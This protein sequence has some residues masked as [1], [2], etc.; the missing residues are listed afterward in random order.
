VSAVVYRTA[1]AIATAGALLVAFP[2]LGWSQ[3]W[4]P[5]KGEG[6]VSVLYQD[7]FV[8]NHL[9][10]TGVKQDRGR[11]DSNNLLVDFTYGITDRL[12]ILLAAP[13]IRTRYTGAARHPGELDDG[14]P[15]SGFQDLRFGV[16]YNVFD[17]PVTITP[18]VG[19]SVPSHSYEY[20]AHAAFGPRVRE[21][22]VGTY[23]G[24]VVALGSRPAFV[25]ARLAYGF[26]EEIAGIDRSRTSL[27]F[28]AG[29]FLSRSV[30]VF[31]TSAGQKTHGGIDLPDA[32]WRAMPPELQEHHDRIARI[33]V[34]DIGGG[35]QVTLPRSFEVFAS[36]MKTISGENAHALARGITIGASWS[37]GR[38][39]P[40]LVAAAGNGNEAERLLIRC[41]CQKK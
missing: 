19:T 28:E 3:A 11:I 35:V 12:A 40:P 37:F 27:D 20:F 14:T 33:D 17:G 24:R 13:Y 16:R 31:A 30:R 5:S 41:L 21:L 2:T 1:A 9:T 23:I 7:L 34:V 6:S 10:A 36:F 29:Y 15:H 4:V 8:K 26:L 18:F 39:V 38:G 25:Q 22:E 32:G